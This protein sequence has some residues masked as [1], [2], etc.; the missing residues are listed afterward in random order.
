M[1]TEVKG[2]TALG[3]TLFL[4]VT[5]CSTDDS[6]APVPAGG[7]G[8]G[9]TGEEA[10]ADD[11][12]SEPD[13]GGGGDVIA[14]GTVWDDQFGDILTDGDGNVLYRFADDARNQSSCVDGCAENWPPLDVGDDGA[15]VSV[16]GAATAD[17]V[18]TME[19]DDGSLQVAYSGWPLYTYVGDAAP[20]EV[21][22]QGVADTWYV[23]APDGGMVT[24][25]QDGAGDS[26]DADGTDG[27]GYGG[28]D[29]P[30][31]SHRVTV[32]DLPARSGT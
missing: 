16:E 30:P 5:G 12:A 18:A 20:G 2:A 32:P 28:D 6:A 15:P 13:T 7:A 31:P 17:L 21:N 27:Y 23:V 29:R 22:G 1:N 9:A 25:A 19:R 10:P 11:G 26:A 8:G 3:L 24:A 4:L 14:L